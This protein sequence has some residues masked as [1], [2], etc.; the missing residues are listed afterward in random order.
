M[1]NTAVSIQGESFLI[2]GRLTYSEIENSNPEAH[3]LL[4]NA[5][6]IQGVFDDK[7]APERFC[8]FGKDVFDPAEHTNTLIAALPEWYGYG[9]RGFTVGFQGGGPCFTIDNLTLDNNPYSADG[10]QLD[11]AYADRMDNLIRGADEAGMVVIVSY[12]Y[13]AQTRFLQDGRAVRKA[14]TT[15]S[16]FLRDNGYTNV[17]I[18]IANEHDVPPF[19]QHPLIYYPEGVAA[20]IDLA[21]QESGG[22]AVG[23]SGRGNSYYREIA[24]ASDL[25]LIHGNGTT[26]QRLYNM[27]Q[28]I[29]SWN[30][31]KPIVCN[32][33]SQA[34]GQME[35]TFR[36]KTSWGY[37]NNMTK[38]EPPADWS[39]TPGEDLFFARRMAEGIGI[40]LPPLPAEEQYYLQGLEP[41][42]EYEGERWV[43]LASL[44]PETINFVD[45]YKNDELIYTAYDEPF[46]VNFVTNWRQGG[47]KVGPD[48][49]VW[50]AVIHLRNG[51]IIEKTA[52]L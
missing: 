27:I 16:N 18:E 50:R 43:R 38:Q 26:R 29:R 47:I 36:T 32:E 45:F 1:P 42:W 37:Y 22:I 23:C 11:P 3:G 7:A 8:R 46:A 21:R 4:M 40:N 49:K 24:E 44:Y 2:N 20:L 15:T 17:M 31:N 28:D 5:R 30:L 39:V 35:V 34:I 19:Q 13:G 14:V 33:D 48:D 41:D 52:N 25:I 10:A 12:F 6:F 51:D 9:L